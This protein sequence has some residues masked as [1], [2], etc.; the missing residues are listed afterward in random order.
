MERF[1]EQESEKHTN[2]LATTLAECKSQRPP[3]LP[4]IRGDQ[5]VE[6]DLR[7]FEQHMQAYNIV[8][9]KW[10]SELRAI[11]KDSTLTA[12]LAVP[13]AQ[14]G[15][16]NAIKAAIL[17]QAGILPTTHIQR[18]LLMNPKLGITAV[19][20]YGIINDILSSFSKGKTLD[21]Q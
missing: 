4:I 17:T 11:F 14:E 15:N 19:Q 5:H 6:D 13:P 12:S 2:I 20:L 16:Y 8:G 3:S 18:L 9:T 21:H 10:P 1:F 7:R